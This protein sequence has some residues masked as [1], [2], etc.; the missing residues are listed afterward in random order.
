MPSADV[1]CLCQPGASRGSG[2]PL[3]RVGCPKLFTCTLDRKKENPIMVEGL[4][5]RD[6]GVVAGV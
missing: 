2:V 6:L 5:I 4:R 1:G 3:A